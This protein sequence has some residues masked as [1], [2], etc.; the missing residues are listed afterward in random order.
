MW[1]DFH[2]KFRER[3]KPRP[4]LDPRRTGREARLLNDPSR[5]I[6]IV[7]EIL[8][9][10]LRRLRAESCECGC[11]GGEFHAWAGKKRCLA[12]RRKGAKGEQVFVACLNLNPNLDLNLNLPPGS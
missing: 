5:D 3:T 9:E 6:L 4:D 7:Q 2:G 1:R 12:Q 10:A 11:D 8:P